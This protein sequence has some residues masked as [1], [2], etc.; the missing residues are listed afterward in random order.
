MTPCTETGPR[1]LAVLTVRNEGPFLIDWL[2]H[3]RAA[4]ITDVLAMSN[5]CDDGTD[6]MLDRLQALGWLVHLPNPGPHPRGPQWSAL[7][8]ADRHRA[9]IPVV[10]RIHWGRRRRSCSRF[11]S[12]AGAR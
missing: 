5:D 12:C 4:G 2:A 11:P 1:I 9:Q 10:A 8:L 6:A 3:H 7:A